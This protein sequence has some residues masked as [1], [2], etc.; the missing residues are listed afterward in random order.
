MPYIV[1]STS[2]SLSCLIGWYS[3]FRSNWK[4][5][6][7][8]HPRGPNRAYWFC[9]TGGSLSHSYFE[10]ITTVRSS[11]LWYPFA[12]IHTHALRHDLF[13]FYGQAKTYYLRS[14]S[15][16]SEFSTQW[17]PM[18]CCVEISSSSSC[19]HYAKIIRILAILAETNR[20]L[21]GLSWIN[22][23]PCLVLH[24]YALGYW[25]QVLLE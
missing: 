15:N 21:R 1:L 14:R 3:L 6:W 25:L 5:E 16:S 4:Q 24:W 11:L 10:Y 12:A 2:F 18:V 19:C 7:T 13:A 9:L 23:A 22:C 8:Y 20:L 17:K